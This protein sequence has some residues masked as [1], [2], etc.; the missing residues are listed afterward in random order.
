MEL[1]SQRT[2][3]S[4]SSWVETTS[5]LSYRLLHISSIKQD[6]DFSLS[7]FWEEILQVCIILLVINRSSILGSDKAL[8]IKE[9]ENLHTRRGTFLSPLEKNTP[10]KWLALILALRRIPNSGSW[11]V[12]FFHSFVV[13]IPFRKAQNNS[14]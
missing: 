6:Y 8:K 4:A 1:S 5:F 7:I 13:T 10:L 12:V 3:D 14:L 2:E 9:T 11:M